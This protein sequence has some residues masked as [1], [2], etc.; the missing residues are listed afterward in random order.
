MEMMPAEKIFEA[1]LSILEYMIATEG[2]KL[3]ESNLNTEILRFFTEDEAELKKLRGT[4]CH[5][6]RCGAGSSVLGVTPDG[7]LLPC[8]RFSWDNSEYFLGSLYDNKVLKK[9]YQKSFSSKVNDFHALVPKSWYD[10][11]SCEA[12]KTCG[13]GCQAFI[14]R[15]KEKA[16]VDCL[17]TKMRYRFYKENRERLKPVYEQIIISENRSQNRSKMS[18]NIKDAD[19][20]TKFYT[21]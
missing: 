20:K 13:F 7:H 5:E 19:G 21:V 15:S 14:V 17:P 8:G 6:K 10:C 16:N 4:L 2:K 1:Q 11:Q 9:S 3:L 12:K 18:F